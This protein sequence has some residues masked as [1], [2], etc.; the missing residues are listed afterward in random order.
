[1]ICLLGVEV[2]VVLVVI[3]GDVEI[4]IRFQ[5][6]DDRLV[7]NPFLRQSTEVIFGL[8]FLGGVVVKNGRPV[9][10]TDVITLAIKLRR[11]VGDKKCLKQLVIRN[12]SRPIHH[13]DGF[14]MARSTRGHLLIG[15]VGYITAGIAGNNGIHTGQLLELG[16]GAPKAAAGKRGGINTSQ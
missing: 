2:I 7:I 3:F 8:F 6:G 9:L 14:G 5:L 10:G 12:L 4:G 1:A 11:V 13:V 16:F 15:W